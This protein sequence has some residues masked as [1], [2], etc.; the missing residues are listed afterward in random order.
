MFKGKLILLKKE[1]L[2]MTKDQ[3]LTLTNKCILFRMF[4]SS[5]S[6]ETGCFHEI[7]RAFKKKH[8]NNRMQK[9]LEI[10]LIF[11]A[12]QFIIK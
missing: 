12:I 2:K 5:V 8:S 11:L 9:R 1:K 3:R 10:H 4:R 7:L 6:G